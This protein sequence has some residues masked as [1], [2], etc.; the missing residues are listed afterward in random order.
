MYSSWTVT[1]GRFFS[2]GTVETPYTIHQY[3]QQNKDSERRTG[4]ADWNG[5]S[6][7]VSQIS[8]SVE[9]WQY[10]SIVPTRI[11]AKKL[12]VI[13]SI[14]FAGVAAVLLL[15]GIAAWWFT[16]RNYRPL[17][18]IMDI[19]SDKV[20]GK[21]EQPDDEFGI[22]QTVLTRAWE[23]Q[24]QFATRLKEQQSMVRSS[25]LA[26]LLKGRVQLGEGLAGEMGRLGLFL[27]E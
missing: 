18:R 3:L 26:R 20:K 19:I 2:T 16:R 25:F 23:E 15:G 5:E 24:D 6:V 4:T 7:T 14:T 1:G 10:V 27:G 8:S 22:L 11:Y 12:M 17:G 13:R 21:L 9:D